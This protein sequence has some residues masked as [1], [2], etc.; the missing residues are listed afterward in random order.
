MSWTYDKPKPWVR[1]TVHRTVKVGDQL[2]KQNFDE[3]VR[4]DDPR[5]SPIAGRGPMR[6]DGTE[7]FPG[8][9]D[10][11]SAPEVQPAS[12]ECVTLAPEAAPAT[13]TLPQESHSAPSD[14]EA[15]ALVKPPS[16]PKKELRPEVSVRI[17]ES[18]DDD[19]YEGGDD[20]DAE[21]DDE[22]PWKITRKTL[23][24]IDEMSPSELEALIENIDANEEWRNL[25]N[26]AKDRTAH[27]LG[28]IKKAEAAPRCEY[29][30]TDGNVCGSP[31]IKGESF[32]YFH[33]EA[34]TRRKTEEVSNLHEV[35]VLEDKI[36]L[37]LAITRFCSTVRCASRRNST[38]S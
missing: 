3:W 30:K 29:T 28:A 19:G 22:R 6:E 37:Q 23:R 18:Y 35:P 24:E 9:S 15:L 17:K 12:T 14:T 11:P 25:R 7:I 33:G 36:S 13:P 10:W 1:M 5:L 20:P 38:I 16:I 21:E 8:D 2:V 34:R 4:H 27:W 31:A 26:I 32:C